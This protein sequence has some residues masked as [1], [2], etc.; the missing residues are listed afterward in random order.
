V[1]RAGNATPDIARAYAELRSAG[2]GDHV[3]LL[4]HRDDV[5]DLLAAA[6]CFVLPSRYEGVAG[7]ALEAMGLGV[8]VVASAL[9]SMAEA[10]DDG[11]SGILVSPGDPTALAAAIDRVLASREWSRAI[12]ERG[13]ERFLE[14]F[15]ID[16]SARGMAD[17]YRRVADRHLD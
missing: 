5:P 6:D 14:R 17:L 11:V 4:G 8:P 12:G 2:L 10:I 13:R 9:P 1:G 7:A 16:H 15:T 3:Q